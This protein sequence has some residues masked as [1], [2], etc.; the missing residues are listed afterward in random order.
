MPQNLTQ[1]TVNQLIRGLITEAGE[2][3]FPENASVDELNCVLNRDG[4]RSRRKGIA[5][6]TSNVLSS[7]NVNSNNA[8]SYGFWRNPAGRSDLLFL[9]IQHGQTLSFYSLTSKPYSANEKT[10][11]VNLNTFV[12]GAKVVYSYRVDLT[13]INGTLVVASEAINTFYV[14][15]DAGADTITSTAISFVVRDFDWQSTY[16]TLDQSIASG[17]VTDKRKYDTY[18]AGWSG[19]KGSKA[20]VL[21]LAATTSVYGGGTVPTTGATA[22]SQYPPLTNPWYIGKN[23]TG[24]FSVV[25]WEKIQSTSSLTGN[26]LFKLN[27]FSKDRATVSGLAG[28]PV[29]TETNRFTTVE[30]H[31]GRIWYSGLGTGKNSGVILY[32]QVFESI[33]SDVASEFIGQCMQRND[34]TSEDFSDLLESDG[35]VIRI[36]DAFNIQKIYSYGEHLFV[37]A[38]NGVWVVGGSDRKFSPTGY[39]VNKVSQIGMLNKYSFVVAEGAPLWW[40]KNGIHTMTFDE[41]SGVPT[42]QNISISTVQTLWD[43]ISPKSKAGVVATYDYVNKRVYWAYPENDDTAILRLRRVLV[44]DIELKAFYPWLLANNN[45]A[46]VGCFFTEPYNN[47][48]SS[49]TSGGLGDTEANLVTII[50]APPGSISFGGFTDSTFFDFTTASYDSYVETGYDFIGDLLLK[51]NAPYVTVYCRSTEDGFTGDETIGYTAIDASSLFMRAYWD[52]K[53]TNA[54]SQ[55]VYR[56]KPFALVN[57]ADLTNNQQDRTVVTSRLK[58]RGRGRSMRL[59]FESEANKNF[60]FLG[61]SVLAGVNDKF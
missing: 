29:E 38:D 59:R 35:G 10:F 57:P 23:S 16:T 53:T 52:F 48:D 18:N 28:Y 24:D 40:S 41:T 30:S 56:V 34:P 46:M 4:S 43:G 25:E 44:L 31:A 49:W 47:T 20:L 3:G 15:Y 8:F 26:G 45:T 58:V 39:F 7:F 12:A 19:D 9:V 22:I 50:K 1:R 32:S 6:E 27:F 2:L 14:S 36:P 17:S 54:T 60:I 37:F 55:Q 5:Y 21:Y 61:Y 42:E 13:S 11:S 51:K 33:K